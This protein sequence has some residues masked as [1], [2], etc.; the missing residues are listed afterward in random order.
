VWTGLTAELAW[1]RIAP[2]PRDRREVATMLITSAVMPSVAS[3]H[4]ARGQI[5]ARRSGGGAP[6]PDPRALRPLAILLDRDGTLVEDVPY[7]DDPEH[8]RPLAG[9]LNA[10]DRARAA[11]IKL[12]VVSNQSGVGRG[13]IEPSGLAQVN[14][15][16]EELLG[17]LGPWLICP[18]APEAGCA[19]RKPAPGLILQA[20]ERLGVPPSR[21]AMIGDIGADVQAADTAGARGVLVPT[22]HTR[23]EEIAAAP[24]VADSFSAAV[25]RLLGLNQRSEEL[26]AA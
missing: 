10:L 23:R 9:V 18:H 13:L 20:A 7:N 22:A 24:E 8:V 1:A 4:A 5:R 11:G 6:V 14:Q 21:C 3:W 25:D 2:G 15:R 12:A 17:P 16:V 19:C 26:V